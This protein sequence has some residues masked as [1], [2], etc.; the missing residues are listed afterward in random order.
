M[1]HPHNKVVEPGTLEKILNKALGDGLITEAQKTEI[2]SA[3]TGDPTTD[4]DSVAKAL[5]AV[6]GTV[7]ALGALLKGAL[8]TDLIPIADWLVAIAVLLLGVSVLI[9]LWNVPMSSGVKRAPVD[10]ERQRGGLR[11]SVI[12]FGLSIAAIA[13][14]PTLSL[15]PWFRP[16]TPSVQHGLAYSVDSTRAVEAGFMATGLTPFSRVELI[17][18]SEENTRIHA[19]SGG[20]VGSDGAL[21]IRLILPSK[22]C[23]KDRDAYSLLAMHAGTLLEKVEVICPND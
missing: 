17:A 16:E 9:A 21:S 14:V 11:I 22:S 5:T 15:V 1:V 8:F 7:A 18:A 13:V 10:R 4:L 19:I 3:V 12:F 2:M 23:S 6:I 20:V